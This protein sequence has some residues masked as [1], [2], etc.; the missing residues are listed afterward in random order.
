[1]V[2]RNE[3]KLCHADMMTGVEYFLNKTFL[4]K[5]VTV[6][7]VRMESSPVATFIITIEEPDIADIPEGS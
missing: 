5:P 4:K 6:T 7:N 2:G 3:I 1:M